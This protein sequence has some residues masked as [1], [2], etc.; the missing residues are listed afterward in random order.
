[1]IFKNFK[2]KFKMN[3][4]PYQWIYNE[5][6]KEYT[7]IRIYGI[8]EENENVCL[9]VNDF[10]PYCY[11]E[12]PETIQWNLKNSKL[13]VDKLTSLLAEDC[14]PNITS[15]MMKK[16]LYYAKVNEK[17]ERK[18][19][20]FLFFSFF[21]KD[22]M[23]AL[24]YKLKYEIYV[25]GIGK[26]KMKIHEDDA[27][28]ILQLTSLNKISTA[29]WISF[30]GKEVEPKNK[31]TTFK[32]EYI[33]KY[34]ALKNTSSLTVG[35]PK[36]LSFDLEC[37]SSVSSAMPN[38]GK[39][40]DKIFQ[41]SCVLCRYGESNPNKELGVSKI[42]LTLGSPLQNDVGKD[43]KII[44]SDTED[45]LL[46]SFQKLVSKEQ[47]NIV[48]GYNIFNFD[49]PYLLKRAKLN[50]SYSDFIMMG[51][52]P[53][54]IPEEKEI[55]WSSS[56]Y[57][58]QTF[59]YLDVEG[60]LWVDLLPIVKRDYGRFD[61]Y[62]LKKISTHF[63]GATKDPLDP[64]GIFECY[65]LGMKAE[66][67]ETSEKE[68][69]EGFKALSVCGKYCVQDSMLVMRLFFTL[70]VWTGL[71]AMAS[72]CNVPIFTTYTQGQQIKVYSQ[73]YKKCTHEN[74]VLE[75]NGYIT[76]P[77]DI[78]IGA[79]VFSPIA[80]CYDNVC[81]FDF[82]S[83]YP[84]TII[85][86]NIC[87]STLVDEDSPE[88]KYITDDMCYVMEWPEHFGCSHDPKVIE[89]NKL[90]ETI[91]TEKE[92]LK[93]LR[94]ERDKTKNKENREK[95]VKKINDTIESLK[96]FQE[97]RNGIIKTISKKVVC[98]KRYFRWLKEP[99]GILPTVC[100]ELLDARKKAKN[101]MKNVKSK[102]NKLTPFTPEYNLLQTQYDVLDSQQ[103][104][105]KVS[106]NS[107]YGALGVVR[108]YLPFMPAAMCTTYQ[109]RLSI[110]KASKKITD[111]FEGEIVYGDSVAHYTPV[112]IRYKGKIMYRTID[113]LPIGENKF[114]IEREKE[115]CYPP[116][117]GNDVIEVWSDKG[118]TP[119]RRIIK[120]LTNKDMY[121][122]N[123]PTGIISI[124]EDHSLLDENVKIVLTSSLKIGSKLLHHSLPKTTEQ[125]R[126]SCPFTKG[127]S[128]KRNSLYID[129]T[130]E[131]VIQ[132]ICAELNSF[133]PEKKFKCVKRE[134][135]F[136]RNN[137]CY[138]VVDISSV[139]SDIEN[140]WN[141]IDNCNVNDLYLFLSG[142]FNKTINKST[143]EIEIEI[144]KY[145]TV[146]QAY[147]YYILNQLGFNV[148]V[149]EIS[150]RGVR[151]D[152]ENSTAVQVINK[153]LKTKRYVYDLETD[154]HHFSCG[155]GLL[156]GHNTDSNYVQFPKKKDFKECWAYAEYVAEE[157][158]KYFPKPQKLAFEEKV[159]DRFLI[160]TK[161]RYMCIECDKNGNEQ[162]DENGKIDI[163]KKGVL[164][165]RRD[166]CEY[167]R[168]VYHDVVMMIFNKDSKENVLNFILDEINKLLSHFYGGEYFR[169]TKAV[170]DYGDLLNPIQTVD[171]KTGK[172]VLKLGDYTVKP[173]TDEEMKMSDGSKREHYV[174]CL[175][176]QMVLAYKMRTLRGQIVQVSSRIEYVIIT[177]DKKNANQRDKIEEYNY[178]MRHRNLLKIDYFDY[179][180][181]LINPIDQLL[182][183]MYGRKYMNFV[184]EQYK[185][186]FKIREAVIKELKSLSNPKIVV[187]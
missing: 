125:N 100:M 142:Y 65:E 187:K 165:T 83:L 170:G 162:K 151:Y 23:K 72:V 133:Y 73:I 29:G 47:P 71:T 130:D 186:R 28:P 27:P 179:L 136:C 164:L 153:M 155:V 182:E 69:Q 103:L 135:T 85:A 48:I 80:G 26:I 40:S 3:F 124:T 149:D 24:S 32:K 109:G 113:N 117:T 30:T 97:K 21:H 12:L 160:I 77:S 104:A 101:E 185:Y 144:S 178:Y 183:I 18:L 116:Q 157:V 39:P 123:T 41:I 148:I 61:S 91:F 99:I 52:N 132:K 66:L 62:T 4:F 84:T 60:I 166:N 143:S 127:F 121:R 177:S 1:M 45:D 11:I 167:I 154:N 174:N 120:H 56:A 163:V 94:A 78:Y 172:E 33:V 115:V 6:E 107:V 16:K 35:K 7:S 76:K 14:Y 137:K 59:T 184:N 34:K 90:D 44:K 92:K 25:V 38:S 173:L 82:N 110:E 145:D 181:K 53:D 67:K 86:Y 105:L 175:P 102:M 89:R 171:P 49:I 51:C 147:F 93:I 168:K 152:I 10:T 54:M 36:I 112:L 2:L 37:F 58:N 13:V 17:G 180:D 139:K 70:N 169:I 108:G 9:H 140:V 22:H 98:E 176:A 129:N 96:P 68:K 126:M 31:S 75:K 158:S 46:L 88:A 159:Y 63:L 42:L 74:I 64:K 43:V 8:N 114:V 19:Y 156:V 87:Y 50:G 15:F 122:V 128:F 5:Q 150:F 119:I 161:K 131:S 111:E 95:I 79:T 106:C 81:P 138:Y 134:T 141:E 146:Q 118:F 20:P 57:K 55:K